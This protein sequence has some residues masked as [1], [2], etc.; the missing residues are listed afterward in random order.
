[1]STELPDINVT[2]G[3]KL[4]AAVLA[5]F[6]L[7]GGLWVYFEPLPR[8]DPYNSEEF[9]EVVATREQRA[10]INAGERADDALGR[11]RRQ[12][13]SR[14]REYELAREDYRTDLDA[15]TS[16]ATTKPAFE[17]ARDRL[18]AARDRVGDAVAE[19]NRL[20]PAAARARREVAAAERAQQR[21]LD[22]AADRAE[23]NT[24]LLRLAWVLLTIAL[25]FW[26]FNTLRK[27]RSA[28]FVAGVASVIAATIQALVMAGDYLGD[29]FDFDE[30]GPLVIAIVGTTATML[31]LVGLERYLARRAPRRRVRRGQ[32][33]YCAY[34]V[35]DAGTHCEG[36][37]RAT[38]AACAT[39]SADRRVGTPHCA[40]CGAA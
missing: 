21:R 23:R 8:E 37:G 39:C 34:P 40:A 7:I 32:C 30:S 13:N 27:R 33:P 22:Q 26:L 24:V 4:L 12:L 20:R 15:G 3:E 17:R 11:A 25:A 18:N 10:A 36:C 9:H 5:I 14:E 6:L 28:Y 19:L 35:R 29:E 1:M 38:V 31:S 16:V 2:R